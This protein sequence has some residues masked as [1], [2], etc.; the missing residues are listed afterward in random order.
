MLC[1]VTMNGRHDREKNC[2]PGLPPRLPQTICTTDI[3]I[4]TH[5]IMIISPMTSPRS[6]IPPERK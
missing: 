5:Q 4:D 2:L 3:E 6:D 1:V